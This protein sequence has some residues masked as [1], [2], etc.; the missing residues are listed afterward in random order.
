MKFYLQTDEYDRTNWVC[1]CRWH[2]M[3]SV[4][5]DH[6]RVTIR[7]DFTTLIYLQN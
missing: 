1:G 7:N 5:V 4:Q 6:C 2:A 3:L